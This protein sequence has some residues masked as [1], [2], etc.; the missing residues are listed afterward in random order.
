[1]SIIHTLQ[2]E[3]EQ[4]K[5]KIYNLEKERG[6]IPKS[7][8][9]F[10]RSIKATARSFGRAW[11]PLPLYGIH[12]G[13]CVD[14]RDPWK[15]GRITVYC[16]VVHNL[17]ISQYMTETSL[18]WARPCSAFGAIDDMGSIFIPGIQKHR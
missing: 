17:K 14:T 13:V 9:P 4:L 2:N 5:D 3:L 6:S 7:L 16:P 1:M 18:P 8:T 11:I 10:N 12:L 15:M